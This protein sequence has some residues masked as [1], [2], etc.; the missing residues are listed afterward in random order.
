VK[1]AVK[2]RSL[3]LENDVYNEQCCL[4]WHIKYEL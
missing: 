2:T 1:N 3:D 4:S